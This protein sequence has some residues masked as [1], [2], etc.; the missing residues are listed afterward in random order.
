MAVANG[1]GNVVTS[2]SI[3][4]YDTGDNYNSYI[5]EP[6]TNYQV[7]L[8]PWTVGGI[9]TDVTNTIDQGPIT[10]AKTWK[11]EK[12]GT[13]NQWNGW[14]DTYGGIW[15][16][17][18]GDIWT[19]SYWYKTSAP[20]GNTAFGIGYFYLSNWSAP[21]NTSIL[22]N[23]NGIIADGQW[24]Y[25]YTTT[26]FNENYSNAI[27]VDGP[28]WGYSTQAGTLYINGLQ[29]EKKPHPTPF[30]GYTRSNTQGL[31][32]IV[33]NQTLN[34]STVSFDSNAQITFDGTNDRISTGLGN[35]GSN[36]SFTAVIN[37][38][39]NATTYN[40]YIGQLLP[41]MGV[42][43]GNRIIFSDYINSSQQTINTTGGTITTGQNH[44]VV[45]TREYDGTNTTNKIYIDGQLKASGTFSGAPTYY[46][47]T[48][49]IGD[50]QTSIW[51]PFYGYVKTAQIYNRT[52]TVSE[53]TQNYQKYK[54]R[55]N[56][57]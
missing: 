53:I 21:Y 6:T 30:A 24:H 33:S 11:F 57:S 29:W 43:N 26:Q 51:Y 9:N 16:G 23:S 25:N 46:G 7:G 31:L 22:A 56:L 10:N 39:G 1:Y 48:I 52:L 2:G 44:Y 35:I 55:F 15:T 3:F 27:I 4:M 47:D 50:G 18:S 40:M 54:T 20:A 19:T 32:P 28:S 41:Y 14:E 45:C 49:Y 34:L 36:V 38:S 37:S 13:S 12:T 8:S 17:N 5:G 42:Y